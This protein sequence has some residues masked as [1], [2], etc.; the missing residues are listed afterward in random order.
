MKQAIRFFNE[1]M[2]SGATPAQIHKNISKALKSAG[3]KVKKF[4]KMS[5]G[6]GGVWGGFYTVSDGMVLPFH[7]KKDGKVSYDAGPKDWIIGNIDYV[8][9]MTR[10]LKRVKKMPG[11]GQDIISN[12][13]NE[14]VN[15]AIKPQGYS[16]LNTMVKHATIY[17][18]DL[19]KALKKQDD[20]AVLREVHFLAAQFTTMEKMMKDKKWNAKYNESVNEGFTKYHIRLTDTPGWYGVWDKKGKQKFEGDRRYVTRQ[21]KKLKTRMGN[22]QLKSLIDVATKRKGKDIEFDVV[23]S[24]NEAVVASMRTRS[25]QRDLEKKGGKLT[26]KMPN[27]EVLKFKD[28]ADVKE[29]MDRVHGYWSF[30]KGYGKVKG[31]RESTAAYEKA[32]Q[33]IAKDKQMSMLSK[34]DRETLLKVA[35][36]MKSANEACGPAEDEKMDE[37]VA[38]PLGQHL[39]AATKELDYMIKVGPIEDAYDSPKVSLKVIKMAR[40]LLDKVN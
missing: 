36:L 2:G 21:L 12:Q 40:K 6:H 10:I 18:R 35:K 11:Y 7:V 5:S 23:E 13:A 27:G 8:D 1:A 19:S 24:V 28:G 17:L 25:G 34:K 26:M 30:I 37:K 14:S 22:Y 38:M 20:D 33:K 4:Q 16:Q 29:Y 15:E 3:F 39:E 31:L 9:V 32:L